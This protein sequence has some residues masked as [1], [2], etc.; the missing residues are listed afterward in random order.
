MFN[1]VNQWE[2]RI[3]PKATAARG[4][5]INSW[6]LLTA[7]VGGYAAIGVG[8]SGIT[9]RIGN[10]NL[11]NIL[12]LLALGAALSVSTVLFVRMNKF[13]KATIVAAYEALRLN[14]EALRAGFS[15]S[16]LYRVETFDRFV[17]VGRIPTYEERQA[18]GG[19]APHIDK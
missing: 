16:T 15:T 19:G 8:L 7:W 6:L 17:S 5:F 13:Q 11:P 12:A 18:A 9:P 3:G 2:P 1:P 14:P 10:A 4:R